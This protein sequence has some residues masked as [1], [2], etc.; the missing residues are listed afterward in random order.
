MKKILTIA[1][2]ILVI[3]AL[4]FYITMD[5][6][7]WKTIQSSKLHVSFLYPVHSTLAADPLKGTESLVIAYD[8]IPKSTKDWTISSN[9]KREIISTM[10]CK[11]LLGTGTYLPIDMSKAMQCGVVKST[12]GLVSVYLI[13]QGRP[14]GGTSYPAS[15]MITLKDNEAAVL[16]KVAKFEL[17]EKL[18]NQKVQTFVRLH[19]KAVIWPPDDNA[20]QLYA[21]VEKIVTT[22][23][24]TPSEEVVQGMETLRKIAETVK[25]VK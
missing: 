18:A 10:S 6:V 9:A 1:V 24:S 14:D 25:T 7:T 19:P 3:V 20:K 2:A 4:Y 11:P 17:T 13:G 22:A 23:V 16:G 12:A 15:M 5:R 21:D 8:H